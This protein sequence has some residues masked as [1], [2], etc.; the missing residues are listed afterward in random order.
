MNPALLKISITGVAKTYG[1]PKTGFRALENVD[2]EI[3]A[4]Q[5]V[6]IVGPSG[7]GK[8]TL[9]RM[10][11]GLEVPT[12]G[13]I[14]MRHDDVSR[15]MTAM[16]FQQESVFPWMTV[17]EN[18]AY[19]IKTTGRWRGRESEEKVAYFL[20]K[21]GLSKFQEFYPSQLSGGMKQRL[22]IARA[23]ATDPEVLLMDE[24]FAALDEQNKLL[25]QGEL[26]R[27]WEELRCS[28]V[29]IT[30]GLDEA[31][32]LGDR[33]A[34]MSSAPGRIIRDIEIPFARP[35]DMANMK[36]N[37]DA[38]KIEEELWEVLR[39]EVL[40]ARAQ[41]DARIEGEAAVRGRA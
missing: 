24:P 22:A 29:F 28:V 12:F 39:D 41:E 34:V 6:C 14:S 2:L 15:P 9:L 20:A 36:R 33:V 37:L 30:H 16:I 3:E 35:R 8:S 23:F 17:K 18:A 10:C 31:V 7:C 38:R 19:G 5:F 25:L 26:A 21:T 4:G 27:L 40:A 11:G 13:K 32:L 1:N